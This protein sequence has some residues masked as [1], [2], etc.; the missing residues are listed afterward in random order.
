MPFAASSFP[1]EFLSSKKSFLSVPHF[2][3]F[4]TLQRLISGPASVTHSIGNLFK[5]LYG[6]TFTNT[7][8]PS[9]NNT[10]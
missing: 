5:R 6:R 10:E 9:N 8:F 7:L 4:M 1:E 2:Y 3:G